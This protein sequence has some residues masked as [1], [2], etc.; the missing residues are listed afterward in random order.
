M[1]YACSGATA[2]ISAG[3]CISSGGPQGE[4]KRRVAGMCSVDSMCA[5]YVPRAMR[6]WYSAGEGDMVEV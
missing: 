2:N 4:K 3:I 5:R 6:R 1:M